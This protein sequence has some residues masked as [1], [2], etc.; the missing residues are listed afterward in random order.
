MTLRPRI[1]VFMIRRMFLADS[2]N[3]LETILI[4][5]EKSFMKRSMKVSLTAVALAVALTL[6]TA[7][8]ADDEKPDR[9]GQGQHAHEVF[10]KLPKDS[11]MLIR[12]VMEKAFQDNK[13]LMAQGKK[14]HKEL[15]AVLTVDNFDAAAYTAKQ[16][17]IQQLHD[18]IKTNMSAA[19]A[20]ALAQ[21]S[22]ADRKII[23]DGMA[24]HEAWH[25]GK[26]GWHGKHT[27]GKPDAVDAAPSDSPQ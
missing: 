7:T 11:A 15:L 13:N 24:Q 20:S 26:G 18:K 1:K 9:S 5:A 8:Y 3:P 21:L 19:F 2:L 14:L 16:Q 10:S 22:P 17:E 6:G 12:H 23:A 4:P 25:H 27:D